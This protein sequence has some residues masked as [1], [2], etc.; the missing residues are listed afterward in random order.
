MK[1]KFQDLGEEFCRILGEE[2][3]EASLKSNLGM[4]SN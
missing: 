4:A 2:D 3:E 1:G